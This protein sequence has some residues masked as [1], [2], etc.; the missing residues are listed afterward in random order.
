LGFINKKT[1]KSTPI[2]LQNPKNPNSDLKNQKFS[3]RKAK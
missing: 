3:E 1:K 2:I